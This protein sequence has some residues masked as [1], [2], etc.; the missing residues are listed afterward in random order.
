MAPNQQHQ[1]NTISRYDIDDF[2]KHLRN[3]HEVFDFLYTQRN[4]YISR[5]VMLTLGVAILAFSWSTYVHA[6]HCFTPIDA[7]S[8]KSE[9]ETGNTLVV[10]W[11]PASF[12]RTL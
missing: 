12:I 2:L 1:N 8:A 5:A 9:I 3:Y 6:C 11:T 7:P 4:T 10:Q